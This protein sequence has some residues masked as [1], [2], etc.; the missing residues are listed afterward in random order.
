[1]YKRQG[2]DIARVNRYYGEEEAENEL[3]YAAS[4][5]TKHAADG[6]IVARVSGGGFAVAHAYSCLLYTSRCV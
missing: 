1:M 3:R 5:L 4:E 6:D 2:F